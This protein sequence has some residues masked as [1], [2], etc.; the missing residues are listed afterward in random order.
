MDQPT[1]SLQPEDD[2][3]M[4][5]RLRNSFESELESGKPS[6]IDEW[7]DRVPYWQ[8]KDVFAD[9]LQ[10]EIRF[11]QRRG[12]SID[13]DSYLTRFPDFHDRIHEVFEVLQNR[14]Q[15]SN[16]FSMASTLVPTIAHENSVRAQRRWSAGQTVGV[17]GRYRLDKYIGGGTFGEVW[18]GYDSLLKRVVAV[19]V[20]RDIPLADA[21][22]FRDEAY[23]AAK[24]KHRGIVEIHDVGEVDAGFF[25]IS[26]FIDGTTLA[27]RMKSEEIP[28]DEA[29]RIVRELAL[30]LQKAHVAGLF[31]RD[32]KPSNILLRNDGSPVVVDFGLAVSEEEQLTLE[33][34][35]AGTLV[36]M[37]PE[38]ARGETRLLDGRSD[39]YSLGV[40][41]FQLLTRRLPFQYRTKSDLLEQLIHREVRPLR[42]IDDT[43]PI[44]LDEICLKC[45]AKDVKHRYATGTDLAAALD[46]YLTSI[47]ETVGVPKPTR[48]SPWY[49]D[50]FWNPI[51]AVVVTSLVA[52][53]IWSIPSPK[54]SNPKQPNPEETLSK[55]EVRSALLVAP[56]TQSQ[57]WVPLFDGRVE[58]ISAT[59]QRE[60]DF[61]EQDTKKS[62]LTARVEDSLWLFGTKHAGRSPLRIRGRV[63]VDDW[64]GTVGFVW[65]LSTDADLP[66]GRF[67]SCYACVIERS[68]PNG[69]AYLAIRKIRTTEYFLDKLE[70]GPQHTLGLK[71]IALPGKAPVDLEIV[72]DQKGVTVKLDFIEVWNPVIDAR[73]TDELST[74]FGK[75]GVMIRGKTVVVSD[76]AVSF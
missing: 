53:T 41:L 66:E 26:E 4:L 71:E 20:P 74:T 31:H 57:Q 24:V 76:A 37:S 48:P 52:G 6:T 5:R 49:K 60:T 40:I 58:E 62:K 73:S 28:R 46:A 17:A 33:R 15:S 13:R 59:R 25:I 44:Q 61:Y 23:Q 7:I 55:E 10:I 8:R 45:L 65:G 64:I 70:I 69:S 11:L 12:Q 68:D 42:S 30:I 51:S 38:Q 56:L 19:K 34:G 39:L 9:L 43:I 72:V 21:Q 1:K 29:I 35:I 3:V 2:A 36:Y 50:Y 16:D 54:S 14:D 18:K 67:P 27:E 75:V 22:R 63:T 47:P 32:I